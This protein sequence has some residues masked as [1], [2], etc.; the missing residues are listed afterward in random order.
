MTRHRG[1]SFTTRFVLAFGVLLLT[2]NFMLG[3]VILNQSN[4][5]IRSLINKNML[6]IANTAAGMLDGDVLGA[7][8][9]DDVGG[10]AFND[11]L[12]KLSV[13]QNNVDIHYIYTV[14]RLEGDHFVFVVDPD[15]EEPAEFGE[16]IVVTQG[17]IRAG[18][19]K[20]TVDDAPMADK[21]GNFYSA[22]SP[23]FDSAGKVSGVVGIDF[24]AAWYDQ[25]VREHT[26]SV[27]II[28]CVSA[29]IGS[30]IIALI[31]ESVRRRFRALDAGLST[32]SANV[33]ELTAEID[34]ISGRPP[35]RVQP[36]DD[37][38]GDELEALGDKIQNMQSD[39]RLYLN[40]LQEK[41]Y[42]DALTRVR[43]STAYHEMIQDIESEIAAGNAHFSVAVF[44]VNSLKQINDR[45]GHEYGDSI[46]QGAA[47]AIAEGFDDRHVYRIG[48]DEFAAVLRGEQEPEMAERLNRVKANVDAFNAGGKPSGLTLSLSVGVARFHTEKDTSFKDVFSRADQ[49]M[50][51]C[52]R[53]YYQET[54]GRQ[55]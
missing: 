25:Q 55:S 8:T 33:D 21:W 28:T 27:F 24:D 53:R 34:S 9:A 1:L 19:G 30:V 3:L 44:D 45:L 7:L 15:P 35:K 31:T 40:Y 23:V 51:E 36:E 46:I 10:E 41:A 11:V 20:P 50:Y 16:D 42:I 29:F 32:L 5:A 39:M 17:L 26:L 54:G 37:G 12:K 14:R 6:D 38:F 18:E 13:F 49:R 47:Q 48:G 22:Y 43:S 52:K 2:A 4:S